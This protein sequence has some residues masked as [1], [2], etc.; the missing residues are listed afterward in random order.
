MIRGGLVSGLWLM[1]A[2]RSS[3]AV[4]GKG[5][6]LESI[7]PVHYRSAV[8]PFQSQSDNLSLHHPLHSCLS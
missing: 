8:A 3:R 6:I 7:A 1:I 4:R 5:M 2:I